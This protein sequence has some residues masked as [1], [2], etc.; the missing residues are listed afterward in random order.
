MQQGPE[1]GDLGRQQ[2]V[3]RIRHRAGLEAADLAV[4]RPRAFGKDNQ[5]H[6]RL[7]G[8][9]LQLV[10]RLPDA[11]GVRRR[12]NDRVLIQPDHVRD[13]RDKATIAGARH[14]ARVS[15]GDGLNRYRNVK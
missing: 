14:D 8:D 6:V 10:E 7:G 5:G 12:V 2:G 15:V 9:P 11:A 1:A 3:V 4:L 13:Q